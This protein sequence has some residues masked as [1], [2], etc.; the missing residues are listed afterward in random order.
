MKLKSLFLILTVAFWC[1]SSTAQTVIFEDKQVVPDTIRSDWGPNAKHHLS[2]VFG[3]GW[4]VQPSNPG[5]E[6]KYFLSADIHTGIRYR[7]QW[8]S[9]FATGAELQYV[10][11]I[12]RLK[13]KTGKVLPDSTLN[14]RECLSFQSFQLASSTLVRTEIYIF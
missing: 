4:P 7:R 2:G 11:D 10:A 9:W 8:A 14:D 6:I 3:F 5:A 12:Y 13:Q 1:Q